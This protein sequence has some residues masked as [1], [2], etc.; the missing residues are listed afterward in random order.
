MKKKTWRERRNARVDL[1]LVQDDVFPTTGVSEGDDGEVRGL[2]DYGI[3]ATTTGTKLSTTNQSPKMYPRQPFQRG[4]LTST[5]LFLL[6]FGVT[7]EEEEGEQKSE[8]ELE[9]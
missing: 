9:K 5:V 6:P 2:L 4:T 7:E 1:T 3:L 8:E